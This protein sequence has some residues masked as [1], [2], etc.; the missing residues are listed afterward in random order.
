MINIAPR[1]NNNHF[2]KDL[3]IYFLLSFWLKTIFSKI[4]FIDKI[5][6]N[7]Y[8]HGLVGIHELGLPCLIRLPSLQ[9]QS[10]SQEKNLRL[11]AINAATK[12]AIK[13]ANFIHLLLVSRNFLSKK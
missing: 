5:Y 1:D 12:N 9:I 4:I 3:K 7:Y 8:L 11:K 13:K 2:K 6:I 10:S